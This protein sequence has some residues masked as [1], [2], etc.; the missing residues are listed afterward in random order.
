MNSRLLG[1]MQL[2]RDLDELFIQGR[3]RWMGE[4]RQLMGGNMHDVGRLG[5]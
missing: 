2:G 1:P 3:D 5:A 4:A